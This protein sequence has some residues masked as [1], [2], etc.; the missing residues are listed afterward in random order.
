M[1]IGG[2]DFSDSKVVGFAFSGT[3]TENVTGAKKITNNYGITTI[4]IRTFKL[5]LLKNGTSQCKTNGVTYC[6]KP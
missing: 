3:N 2:D 5:I 1:I 6:K 4:I